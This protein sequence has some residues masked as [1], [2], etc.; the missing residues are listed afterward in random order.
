MGPVPV[1]VGMGD[2]SDAPSRASGEC[3]ETRESTCLCS[4]KQSRLPLL[5]TIIAPSWPTLPLMCLHVAAP[6]L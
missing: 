3:I 6:V 5:Q 2:A 1:L 4:I